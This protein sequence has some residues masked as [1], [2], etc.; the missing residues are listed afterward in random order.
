MKVTV[1]D[2]P[3]DAPTTEETTLRQLLDDL[4]RRG[5]IPAGP[6]DRRAWPARAAPGACR[7]SRS[8]SSAPLQG[9][10]RPG[11]RHHRPARLRPPHPSRRGLHAGRRLRAP[12]RQI[13][14]Q[15]RA[16]SPQEASS[17]LY[18]LLDT[19]QRFLFCLAQVKNICLP[20]APDSLLETPATGRLTDALDSMQACQEAEEWQSLAD[21][22]DDDLLP[23]LEGFHGVV[24][25]LGDAF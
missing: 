10:R 15:F 19:L 11:H 7:T 17:N 8:S 3:V 6:G 24:A 13:S 25:T 22:I 4:R 1:N 20:D 23:A 9:I 14:S 18:N 16:A 5:E 21:R 12:P 2:R